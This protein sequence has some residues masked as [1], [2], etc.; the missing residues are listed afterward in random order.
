MLI[1]KVYGEVFVCTNGRLV[2]MTKAEQKNELREEL[3]VERASLT[4]HEAELASSEVCDRLIKYLGVPRGKQLHVYTAKAIWKEI[5]I[6]PFVEWVK[7]QKGTSKIEIAAHMPIKAIPT[8]QYDIVLIPMVG[9]DSRLQRLGMGM[10]WY[11]M[12]L[13]K[14]K[15]ALKIGIAYDWAEVEELVSEEHDIAMDIIVTPTRVLTR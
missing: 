6:A 12:F 10:G 13:A 14:Q 1:I 15:H 2:G 9:F 4:E 5:D 7:E 8:E 11:D 3:R